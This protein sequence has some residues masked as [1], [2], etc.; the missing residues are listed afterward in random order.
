MTRE[1]MK[2]GLKDSIVYLALLKRH[3]R[4]IRK[5]ILNIKQGLVVPDVR[6]GS[7][8]SDLDIAIS[9]IEKLIKE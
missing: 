1:D 5:R 9:I 6:K 8:H 3:K 4:R 2:E 7:L